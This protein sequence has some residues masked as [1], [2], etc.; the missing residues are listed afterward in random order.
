M[1]LACQLK[2]F[3]MKETPLP[4]TVRALCA[5][6]PEPGDAVYVGLVLNRRGL[7]RAVATGK[8]REIG[9]VAVASDSFGRQN[10]R[11][12]VEQSV[13]M[14]GRLIAD[15]KAAGLR[16]Q[17]TISVAF[18]CP[19][20]GEIPIERVSGI[21]A[22]LARAEPREIALADTIGVAAPGQ[23]EEAFAAVREAIGA[24]PLRAHF[25][26]TR[27]TGFANAYAAVNSGVRTLDASIG[28]IGGCP[29]APRATGNIATED[30]LFMLE[31]MGWQTGLDLEQ[32]IRAAG[33]LG[34]ALR[35]PV[36]GM[37]SRAGTF[38]L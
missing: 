34:T 15:A 26:N 17:V 20:E 37:L 13:E 22:E 4:F 24:V 14:C 10:Q 5:V 6:L 11:Q 9:C 16:A 29:F 8:I 36:P 31:R 12:S 1:G 7:E 27:N 19:F 38:P 30:L 2:S 25:H 23:V 33:W 35:R 18:G 32:I 21:A 28:G 3:S